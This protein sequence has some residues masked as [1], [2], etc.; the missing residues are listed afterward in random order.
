MVVETEV[1]LGFKRVLVFGVDTE[2]DGVFSPY[3][4][5]ASVLS[6]AVEAQGCVA[7]W[8]PTFLPL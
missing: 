7:A 1:C 5:Q 8:A 2:G 3:F 6:F 4:F